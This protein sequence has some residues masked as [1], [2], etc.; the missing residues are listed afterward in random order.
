MITKREEEKK[1]TKP[2]QDSRI[3]LDRPP[4]M[5]KDDILWMLT[6]RSW[7]AGMVDEDQLIDI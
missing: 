2:C 5:K 7:A 3:C 4:Q 1:E 6:D